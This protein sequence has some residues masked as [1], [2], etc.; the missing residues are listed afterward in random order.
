MLISVILACV[1]L[2]LVFYLRFN[3]VALLL[4]LTLFAI[5]YYKVV[6]KHSHN[7]KILEMD[8]IANSSKL[9]TWNVG[10]KIGFCTVMLLTSIFVDSLIVNL[11]IFLTMSLFTICIAGVNWKKYVQL[12]SLPVNFAILSI[13]AI[14]FS[15]SHAPSNYIDF[16]AFGN[17]IVVTADSQT[18]AIHLL[19]RILAA[20]ASMYAISMTTPMGD[21]IALLRKCRVPNTI[22]DLMY[23]VYRFIF[24]LLDSF[25]NMNN[26]AQSRLGYINYKTTVKTSLSIGMNLFFISLRKASDNFVAMESRLYGDGISFISHKNR[27]ELKHLGLYIILYLPIIIYIIWSFI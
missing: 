10:A 8:F 17:Y 25:G 3:T 15:F 6:G 11:Y 12:L 2:F 26:A 16:P 27:L 21:V 14:I 5:G 20:L 9:K 7:N 4:F 24:I 13:I 18:H 22:I 1:A 23:L 19:A